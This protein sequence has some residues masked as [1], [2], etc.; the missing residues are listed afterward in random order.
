MSPL[1]REFGFRNVGKGFA[2]GIHNPGKFVL[3]GSRILGFEFRNQLKESGIPLTIG[4]W[5]PSS[6]DKY[7]NCRTQTPE[8]TAWN[9]E[10]TSVLDITWGEACIKSRDL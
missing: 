2:C 5:N 8:S 4:I 7:W 6:T 1:V 3:V 9:P 10:S